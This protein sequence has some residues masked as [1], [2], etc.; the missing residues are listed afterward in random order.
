MD[1]KISSATVGYL[2]RPERVKHSIAIGGRGFINQLLILQLPLTF[3]V[4]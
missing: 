4:C 1:L 2:S 3:Q